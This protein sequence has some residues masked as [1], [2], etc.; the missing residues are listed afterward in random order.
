M[1]GTIIG[2]LAMPAS[3]Q[4]QPAQQPA[5]G[6]TPGAPAAPAPAATAPA[7]GTEAPA[8]TPLPGSGIIHSI[9]VSGNQRLEPETVVSYISLRVGQPYDREKLDQAIKDLYATELFADVQIAGADT[10]NLLI[11]V[12][13]NPVINRIILEGNK[14]IK[15]DKINP[16][17]KL[18]PRQIFTRSK[19]RADVARIV[20]L[21]RRQ[22]R[23]AASVEPKIVQ[24][25]QNRVD[26]VF[27]INEGPRSHI[28]AINIIGNQ[29]FSAHTLRSQMATKRTGP[30]SFLGSGDVY[31]PDRLAYDQQKLRQFYLTQGY[32]DFRV[33][34]AVAELTPDK[35]D[36]VITYVVE[37]GPR[38]KF[39]DVKVE[40]S[41]RDLK[42][43]PLSRLLPM[44]KGEWYN[45]KQIEDTLTS[46]NESAG[47]FGY[48]FSDVEPDI[49]H[50][51]DARTMS[52]TF[53]V[54]ETPRVYVER[55]NINGNTLTRDKVVRREF[56][57]AEGDP[58][59][60][61]M[62]K[63]SRDRIQSL[64][65]FQDNLE[66]EQ[67]Q[68][69]APDRV[70]LTTNLQE[71]ATGQLEIS[72]GYSSLERFLINLAITQ[73]N[74]MGK[75]ETVSASVNYSSYSKS[76]DLGFT[77]PYV[78]GRNIAMGFDLFRRDFNSFNFIGTSRQTTYD[79][80]S[81]GGTLRFGLALTE[82][83]SLALR[84]Q[85]SVDKVSLDQ[86]TFFTDP[87][88]DGPL[89]PVCDPLK[90][91][92]YLC[93]A[94]GN[95]TT[96]AIGYTLF[97]NNVDNSLRPTRGQRIGFNQDLAGLGG[98]VRYLRSKL[99]GA[100]FW[101]L[102]GNFVFSLSGEAGY[103]H[104]FEKAPAPDEDPVRLTDRFFLG[105]P[106]IRGFDIRGVGPRVIRRFYKQNADGSFTTTTDANN[107]T[108]FVLNNDKNSIVDDA[109]GGRAYYLGRAEIEIP[110]SNQF[111]ELGLRPSVFV[112]VGAVF[113]VR[114]PATQTI[115]PNN[116]LARN[117]C[118]NSG[119]QPS[120]TASDG[121]CATGTNFVSGITPFS[122]Q[123]YGDTP[124]PRVSIGFGVNW[125]SPFGPFRIDIAKALIK[126]PG[127]DTKLVTF[128]VGTAF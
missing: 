48:A 56:R 66:I 124:R 83:W 45:A 43:E 84:Y 59:N 6:L 26:V 22:G 117:H 112:D 8:P 11:Q 68:G 91:G 107:H 76:V 100:K 118:V 90:A 27:E 82:Y 105:E 39:G 86:A 50:D 102:P 23:F 104:S 10:G 21:Y 113:G 93:E 32:A 126:A 46:L 12:R 41:I 14:R 54:G 97:Y 35:R 106:D 19:A 31:D 58:F 122:E 71:K 17:I 30:L 115:D 4:N 61:V 85:L 29:H 1:V 70:V 123:F 52:V 121:T 94:L 111:R 57:I 101:R 51:K 108:V 67:S 16:E 96:S 74:F 72:A 63:R 40:S 95:R 25:E 33:V 128:N 110:V 15:E 20:E 103:I 75:G 38:Y 2:G 69:S 60:S 81:T 24:L 13:E 47:L 73:R 77:E 53:K 37:E 55:I 79:Q 87:D 125:N 9:A 36:F 116:V 62:V 109:I 34:S 18:A 7:Q 80:V 88:G 5:P 44:K 3:A 28:R 78:F 119:G 127:D 114:H 42:A 99:N 98:S 120:E 92:R 89:P 49:R 65:Y 64:G